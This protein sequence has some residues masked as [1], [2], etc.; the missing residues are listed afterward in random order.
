MS[1]SFI[2]AFPDI[3]HSSHTVLMERD[4][5]LLP[6]FLPFQLYIVF[7]TNGENRDFSIL[8]TA[9]KALIVLAAYN[10]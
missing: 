8:L 6:S 1:L 10:I 7:H 5:I 2:L 4:D 3:F 9:L